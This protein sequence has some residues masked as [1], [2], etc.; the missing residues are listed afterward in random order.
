LLASNAGKMEAAIEKLAANDK[1]KLVD[2]IWKTA[3]P[4]HPK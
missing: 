2:E 3:G 1:R 4:A